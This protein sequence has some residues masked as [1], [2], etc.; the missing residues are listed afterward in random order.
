MAGAEPKQQE[1][2]RDLR[3][4]LPHSTILFVNFAFDVNAETHPAAR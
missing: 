2:A 4:A 1:F 3:K